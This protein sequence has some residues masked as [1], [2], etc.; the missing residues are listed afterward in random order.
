MNNDTSGAIACNHRPQPENKMLQA[1]SKI[2][3]IIKPAPAVLSNVCESRPEHH[4]Q[5]GAQAEYPPN[6]GT[7]I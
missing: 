2:A 3:I 6:A 1:L 4:R 5:A 7:V